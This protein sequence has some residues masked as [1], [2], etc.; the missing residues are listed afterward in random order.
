MRTDESGEEVKGEGAYMYGG[1]IQSR[2]RIKRLFGHRKHRCC[3][4]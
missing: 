2:A 4:H 3:G 1:S